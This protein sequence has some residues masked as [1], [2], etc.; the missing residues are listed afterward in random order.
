MTIFAICGDAAMPRNFKWWDHDG[1]RMFH[2][3]FWPNLEID[4]ETGQLLEKENLLP[5]PESLYRMTD[6]EFMYQSLESDLALQMFIFS[7][8]LINEIDSGTV[9]QLSRHLGLP[10]FGSEKR[11]RPEGGSR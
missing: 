8:G 1:G 6:P 5:T 3:N 11:S 10:P 7:R 2:N 9:S 4:L